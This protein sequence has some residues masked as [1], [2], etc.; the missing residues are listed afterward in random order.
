MLRLLCYIKRWASM[1]D[2]WLNGP[3]WYTLWAGLQKPPRLQSL[4]AVRHRSPQNRCHLPHL[5][6]PALSHHSR[7][8]Y[9]GGAGAA[10][11]EHVRLRDRQV[12]RW[13]QV[14]QGLPRPWE[15]GRSKETPCRT[16]D[17]SPKFSPPRRLI[18]AWW[19]PRAGTWWRWRWSTRR[20]WRSTA[21]TIT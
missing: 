6:A 8:A 19:C 4:A 5:L 20:S 2:C 16:S 11:V 1:R 7:L 15:A 3:W 13:G 9:D 10:G 12:H 21:S 17:V 14:R 18:C